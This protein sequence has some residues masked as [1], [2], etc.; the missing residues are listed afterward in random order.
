MNEAENIYS[1]LNISAFYMIQMRQRKFRKIFAEKFPQGCKNIKLL[2]IGCG[3]G[4]WL[5]EFATFG[6]RFANFAG[7]ELDSKRAQIATERIPT[8]DIRHGTASDLPWKDKTFDIVFQSTVFTSVLDMTER[9]KIA[10]EMM[11]VCKADGFILWYD[12]IYNSPSNL[13]VRGVK[14]REIVELF[15][16]WI[17]EFRSVTLAPPI[18]RKLVPISWFAAEFIETLFPF[19]RTHIIAIIKSKK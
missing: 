6:F 3:E 10:S 19:L 14:K 7:I 9:K 5:A 18:A 15:S 17:C 4:Q 16:P 11:R 12:F 13:N 1:P 2:E 8:A